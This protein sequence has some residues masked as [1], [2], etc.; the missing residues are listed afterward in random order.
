[1]KFILEEKKTIKTITEINNFM[2]QV[3]LKYVK[4]DSILDKSFDMSV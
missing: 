1:M 4:I 2:L 3:I